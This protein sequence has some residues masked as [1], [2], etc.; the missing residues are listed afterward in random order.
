[1]RGGYLQH[2]T[3]KAAWDGI[4]QAMDEL[5]TTVDVLDLSK[6]FLRPIL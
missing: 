3:S 6:D 2:C 4:A 5:A 1:M